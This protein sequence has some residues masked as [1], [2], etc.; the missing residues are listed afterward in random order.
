MGVLLAPYTSGMK[1]GSGFNSYTQQLCVDGAVTGDSNPRIEKRIPATTGSSD[2][3]VAQSV[4]FTRS[5][6]RKTSD[7]TQTL[8]VRV[9]SACTAC[10]RGPNALILQIDQWCHDSQVQQPVWRQWPS[11]LHQFKHNQYEWHHIYVQCQSCQSSDWGSHIEQIQSFAEN[12]VGSVHWCL[13]G[14][15]HFWWVKWEEGHKKI[16]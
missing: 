4:T 6:I 1:L 13:W 16:R 7:I 10:S 8:N 3:Q 11:W 9:E 5:R 15:L 12:K 2:K 14:L